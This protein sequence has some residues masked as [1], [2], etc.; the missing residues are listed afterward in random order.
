MFRALRVRNYRRYASANLL[1][2]T[3]TWMQR[4]GQDWLVLQLSDDSGIALG[5]I[6]ALQ[7]GPSL[8]LS[9]YGGVLADRYPKRRL[10]LMTQVLMGLLSLVLGVLVATEAVELWHVFVLAGGLGAVSAVDAPVRQA[11]VS[12]MVGPALLTNAVSLN[13]TIFNGAR[14]VGPALAG[15]LIAAAGGDTAPAFFLNA[16]SFAFTITALAGMRTEEL[17][18]SKP[19]ARGRGQLR[20]GLAYTWAHPDL[21]LAMALAFVLGTF[22]FNYQVTIALM[23]RETFDLGAEAFGLLSTFFAVGSLSGA[24]LSTRRSVRPRQRFLVGSAVVF[25]LF[26]VV[27]GLMPTYASF[28][29]LLIP[30]GAAALVFSVATNSFV[31]LGVDPQMRGRVMALYFMCFMGGTPVGAPLVGWISEHLGAPWGLI[32]GGAVCVVAGLGAAVFL[33]RHRSV[34]LELRRSP[35]RVRL[36]VGERRDAV[37]APQLRAAEET[38]AERAPGQQSV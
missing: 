23:A 22:G 30:T 10:L 29:L 33:S 24:L 15:L 35:L 19:V 25:G 28:A 3:G 7:F 31:Q 14:L 2:L 13:S 12:E 9:M 36:R 34:R 1:S 17:R 27:A 37:P 6:T 5:L 16:V 26:T 4:I 8:L 20:E 21:V 38:L 32:L 18:P 11:F